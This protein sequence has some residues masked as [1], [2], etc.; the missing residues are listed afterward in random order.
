MLINVRYRSR[1]RCLEVAGDLGQG[2]G[3]SRV[4]G[5]RIGNNGDRLHQ[6]ANGDLVALDGECDWGGGGTVGGELGEIGAIDAVYDNLYK[7]IS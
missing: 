2:V 3:T 7:A 6:V 1:P 5:A 4:S